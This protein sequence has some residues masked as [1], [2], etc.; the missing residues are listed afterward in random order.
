[1][2]QP[3]QTIEFTLLLLLTHPQPEK[4]QLNIKQFLTENNINWSELLKDIKWHRVTPQAYESLSKHSEL[5]PDEI[6][7]Q[8]KQSCLQCKKRTLQQAASLIKIAKLFD[9]HNIRFISLKGLTLSQLLYS[10]ITM[11]EAH[12]IDIII[13]FNDIGRAE[14]ILTGAL[15]FTRTIPEIKVT[16]RQIQYLDVRFKDR[17]YQHVENN[18]HLEVHYRFNSIEQC[19]PV[20]FSSLYGNILTV[21]INQQRIPVLSNVHL[22]LYQSVHGSMSGWY[23]LHWLSDIA[24]MMEAKTPDWSTILQASNQYGC[25]RNLV[26]SVMFASSLYQ[27]SPPEQIQ[28]AFK[29]DKKLAAQLTWVSQAI[30]A[31][32]NPSTLKSFRRLLFFVPSKAFWAFFVDNLRIS[33]TDFSFFPLPDR[34]FFIYYWLRPVFRIIR[35]FNKNNSITPS[36]R[37]GRRFQ[38]WNR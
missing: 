5:I 22:W 15:G 35:V 29:A 11:R 32:K 2:H 18:V 13:D 19:L 26:E 36:P 20:P 17:V 30:K 9:E 14:K 23:R 6:L 34:L 16:D 1:M 28:Q 24:S 8:L 38:G 31:R 12:D 37:H 25:R 21:Q 4:Q 27:L 3:V 7:S 33:P 10:D